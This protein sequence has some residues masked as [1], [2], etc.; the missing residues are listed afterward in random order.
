[1]QLLDFALFGLYWMD[2]QKL[3][4]DITLS[5]SYIYICYYREIFSGLYTTN[6][7]DTRVLL[8][9]EK[10]ESFNMKSLYE[11]IASQPAWVEYALQTQHI[12]S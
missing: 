7:N 3:Y 10:H 2:I 8:F 4:Y 6:E 11:N 5:A 1:M 12:Y 9:Y